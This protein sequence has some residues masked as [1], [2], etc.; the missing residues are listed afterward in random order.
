MLALASVH[1]R[2]L[3]H[4]FTQASAVF[5]FECYNVR[6]V[7]LCIKCA[8]HRGVILCEC[9]RSFS[10]SQTSIVAR[11]EPHP[12]TLLAAIPLSKALRKHQEKRHQE[13]TP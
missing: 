9:Q 13:N 1:P 11:A 10:L 8:T 4:T 5:V 2:K 3:T 12:T 6:A 7:T